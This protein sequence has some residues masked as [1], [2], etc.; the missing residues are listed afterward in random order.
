MGLL[1][2]GQAKVLADRIFA[3]MDRNGNGHIGFDEY[4]DYLNVLMHGTDEEK[5]LQSFKLITMAKKEFIEYS[6]FEEMFCSIRAMFNTITG[7][8]VSTNEDQIR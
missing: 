7:N 4:L 6:D 5:A 3:T 2:I 8:E 1:G